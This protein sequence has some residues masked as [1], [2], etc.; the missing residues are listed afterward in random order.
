[1]IFIDLVMYFLSPLQDSGIEK[2]KTRWIKTIYHDKSRLTGSVKRHQFKKHLPS[3]RGD[4]MKS[5]LSF[6]LY[7]GY[8]CCVFNEW[9]FLMHNNNKRVFM[10]WALCTT[11][12]IYICEKKAL[13]GFAFVHAFSTL[14]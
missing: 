6:R 10:F 5:K 14:N 7:R 1:M 3:K 11:L 13:N 9:K 4:S 12:Y 2:H 8:A